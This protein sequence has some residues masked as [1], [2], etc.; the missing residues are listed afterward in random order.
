MSEPA[1][2]QAC[3]ERWRAGDEQA[4]AQLYHRYVE[5]LVAVA[6]RRLSAKLAA[7]LD[8]EDIV[9]SVFRSFFGRAQEGRFVFQ[10]SDDIWKLLVRITIHKTL[11]QVDFHCRG[12]RDPAAEVAP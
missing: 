6:K 9:Q 3:V 11:K 8:P 7:R 4:A 1:Q 5:R 12:K 10:D 2:D